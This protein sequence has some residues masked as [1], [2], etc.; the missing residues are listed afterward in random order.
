[1]TIYRIFK[2]FNKNCPAKLCMTFGGVHKLIPTKY[3]NLL[4]YFI[5]LLFYDVVYLNLRVW[6]LVNNISGSR[7]GTRFR[8]PWFATFSVKAIYCVTLNQIIINDMFDI[9]QLHF[10][11]V[12]LYAR[13]QTTA[14]L[15]YYKT[16]TCNSKLA[17]R[18]KLNA[19]VW[20]ELVLVT[21]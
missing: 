2:I 16:P 5:R 20:E 11:K 9:L 10:P 4:I 18:R 17:E 15:N 3:K 7:A 19:V 8:A 6:Y 14:K 12:T 21:Q 13:N 1:M